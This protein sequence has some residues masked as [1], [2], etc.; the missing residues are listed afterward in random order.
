MEVVLYLWN[1]LPQV[2]FLPP[3]APKGDALPGPFSRLMGTTKSDGPEA[4]NPGEPKK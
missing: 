3:S 2:P 1:L 4:E